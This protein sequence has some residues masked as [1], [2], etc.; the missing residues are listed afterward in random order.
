MGETFHSTEDAYESLDKSTSFQYLMHLGEQH[1]N[2]D[3]LVEEQQ[4]KYKVG[5]KLKIQNDT[6]ATP[7]TFEFQGL[8]AS[9]DPQVAISWLKLVIELIGTIYEGGVLESFQR[10]DDEA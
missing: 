5:M 10:T 9:L 2:E 1:E 7:K 8:E 3:A 4:V 6:V